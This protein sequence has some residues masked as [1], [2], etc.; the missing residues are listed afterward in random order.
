MPETIPKIYESLTEQER[1][2]ADRNLVGFFGLLLKIDQRI[3][4]KE[5]DN[6]NNGNTN[7]TD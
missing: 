1:I 6:E 5:K 3:K 4:A 7:N 2:E